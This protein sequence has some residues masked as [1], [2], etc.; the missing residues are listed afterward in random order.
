MRKSWAK[1]GVALVLTVL[2]GLILEVLAVVAKQRVNQQHAQFIDATGRIQKG[3]AEA[4][5]HETL[6]PPL[7]SMDLEKGSPSAQSPDE[8]LLV[9][10]SVECRKLGGQRVL[11]YKCEHRTWTNPEAPVDWFIPCLDEARHVVDTINTTVRF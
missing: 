2:A 4:Q 8:Q 6:G 10:E 7:L 9:L 1:Y 3:M 5:L 11:A